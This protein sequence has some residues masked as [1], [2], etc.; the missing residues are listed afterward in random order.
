MEMRPL[1]E[2]GKVTGIHCIVRDVTERRDE[3]KRQKFVQ[4]GEFVDAVAHEVNN[5]L[6]V[7]SGKAQLALMKENG[8]KKMEENLRVIVDQCKKAK[9][10][11]E[12]ALAMRENMVNREHPDG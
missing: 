1:R 5:P 4:L 7:V 9:K 11:I 2:S 3:E 10:I 6:Q 8:N 12:T